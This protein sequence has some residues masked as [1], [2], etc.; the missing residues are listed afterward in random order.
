MQTNEAKPKLPRYEE[1]LQQN[2][3]PQQEIKQ[4]FVQE[5]YIWA[6]LFETSRK[7]QLST[8]SIKAAVSSLLNY[9]IFWDG[10]N[11]HEFLETINTSI[12]QVSDL[13]KLV[14][15]ESLIEAGSLELK[16]EPHFLQE[17]LSL[18]RSN[19]SHKALKSNV[20]FH[21]PDDDK[22]IEV[23]YAYLTLA[24][25]LLLE[26]IDSKP[27]EGKLSIIAEQENEIWTVT[28]EGIYGAMLDLIYKMVYCKTQPD[29]LSFLSPENILKLHIA[30]EI[31]HHLG[32]NFDFTDETGKMK[33]VIPIYRK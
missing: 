17:I 28:I 3:A 16:C 5:Q 8:T 11:Q 25:E 13:V 31:I 29:A 24:L 33:L 6:L 14:A 12:D 4:M 32:I 27:S 20:L 21:L 9:D 7:L 23:D 2:N 19:L 22:L 10:A 18:V 30:C 26:V 15:L 1:L